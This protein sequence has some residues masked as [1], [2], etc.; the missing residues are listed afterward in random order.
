MDSKKKCRR[1]DDVAIP[2]SST[3]TSASVSVCFPFGNIGITDLP[4]DVLSEVFQYFSYENVAVQL[5]PVCR[6]FSIVATS[7]L[8]SGFAK[9]GPKISRAMVCTETGMNLAESETEVLIM[10]RCY[11]ALEIIK[12]EY[13]LLRAVTWRYVCN[14]FTPA[15]PLAC[16]YPGELLDSFIKL[17][18]LSGDSPTELSKDFIYRNIITSDLGKLRDQAKK[19]M[20]HFEKYTERKINYNYCVS[21]TKIIDLLDT[22][23]NTDGRK[24]TYK[25]VEETPETG[26]CRI[27]AYYRVKRSWFT[28]LKVLDEGERNWSDEQRYMYMRLRR[29][30]AN[31]NVYI[32]EQMHTE[33]QNTLQLIT[34]SCQSSTYSG[35]GEYGGYFFFYGNMN[36]RAFQANYRSNNE[37][38]NSSDSDDE[39]SVPVPSTIPPQSCLD[40]EFTAEIDCPFELAPVKYLEEYGKSDPDSRYDVMIKSLMTNYSKPKFKLTLEIFCPVSLENRL[41]FVFNWNVSSE[42]FENLDTSFLRDNYISIPIDKSQNSDP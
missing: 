9:L 34:N 3:S 20:N 12:N 42:D 25:Q 38:E 33:R 29:L 2:G 11:N 17:L 41:P 24:N 35:Y 36:L 15:E 6:Q 5:R 37:N 26:Y 4:K 27:T 14:P 21:G 31:N 40:L 22:F 39:G 30:I 7:V 8:N 16:L 10:S 1:I 23:M 19:F 28:A 32:L 18:R 13:L